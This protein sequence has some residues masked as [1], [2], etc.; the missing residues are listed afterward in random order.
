MTATP[1]PEHWPLQ[2]MGKWMSP[3]LMNYLGRKPIATTWLR[4]NQI[5]QV[6]RIIREQVQSGSQVFAITPLIAESEKN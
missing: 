3:R 4:K 5:D 2:P 1:I 6:Y